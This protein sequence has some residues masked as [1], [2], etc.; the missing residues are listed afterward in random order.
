MDGARHEFPEL[1]VCVDGPD[2]CCGTELEFLF[3]LRRPEPS[4]VPPQLMSFFRLTEGGVLEPEPVVSIGDAR[5]GC[6]IGML[7]DK[8]RSG[9]VMP[10]E[11]VHGLLP[12]F[13]A[14]L[15]RRVT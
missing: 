7:S 4:R 14:S 3:F 10:A 8:T 6:D 5:C 9:L 12:N 2:G 13:G 11:A 15:H 1:R